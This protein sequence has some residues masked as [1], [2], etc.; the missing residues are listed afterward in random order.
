MCRP[1]RFF[2][3]DNGGRFFGVFNTINNNSHNKSLLLLADN[4]KL[5]VGDLIKRRHSR[6]GCALPVDCAPESPI[7]AVRLCTINFL[8]TIPQRSKSPV[9]VSTR[10]NIAPGFPARPVAAL[11]H[12]P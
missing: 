12:I 2:R 10:P 7:V 11:P 5:L 9:T 1:F 3:G 4:S 8:A 6:L